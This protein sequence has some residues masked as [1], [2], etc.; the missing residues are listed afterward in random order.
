MQS[1]AK[2]IREKEER[3]NESQELMAGGDE[4]KLEATKA[5]KGQENE[6]FS[7]PLYGDWK[8][9]GAKDKIENAWDPTKPPK[10]LARNIDLIDEKQKLKQLD[11]AVKICSKKLV[12]SKANKPWMYTGPKDTIENMVH[13][14]HVREWVPNKYVPEKEKSDVDEDEFGLD[15]GED[16]GGKTKENK[17][18]SEKKHPS[19]PKFKVKEKER[20]YEK[21]Y[22]EIKKYPWKF[23]YEDYVDEDSNEDDDDDNDSDVSGLPGMG[24]KKSKPKPKA[25]GD[26]KAKPAAKKKKKGGESSSDEITPDESV[27]SDQDFGF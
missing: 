12:E 23:K 25:K 4:E 9:T 22:E 1:A 13:V 21:E 19:V 16:Q 26:D 24:N 18:K 8:Y 3:M 14:D 17:N 15:Q 2:R 5:T 20:M 6:T 10:T 7:G 11:D 27:G